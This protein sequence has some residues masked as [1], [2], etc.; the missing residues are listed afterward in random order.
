MIMRP[1]T[2]RRRIGGARPNR[3]EGDW[4]CGLRDDHASGDVNWRRGVLAREE[5]RP[6]RTKQASARLQY[7]AEAGTTTYGHPEDHI[8]RQ[9]ARVHGGSAFTERFERYIPNTPIMPGL[10]FF[11]AF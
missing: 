9:L 7:S 2:I 11:E 1:L 3:P 10:T 8:K 5:R 4:G 6:R